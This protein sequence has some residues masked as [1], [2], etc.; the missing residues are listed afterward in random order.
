MCKLERDAGSEAWGASPRYQSWAAQEPN[1][2]HCNP[3][4]E[5]G[6]AALSRTV[7]RQSARRVVSRH[8][9]G[10][11]QWVRAGVRW[12]R[13]R[14]RPSSCLLS[15]RH[16]AAAG[17]GGLLRDHTC[18]GTRGRPGT[19]RAGLHKHQCRIR[20]FITNICKPSKVYVNSS[21]WCSTR[22]LWFL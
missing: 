18:R 2:F 21:Q 9:V 10:P 20:Y 17:N 6:R 19:T 12:H 3:A 8:A 5:V 15:W 16:P 13:A 14:S 22:K 1:H 11:A 4:K 7:L